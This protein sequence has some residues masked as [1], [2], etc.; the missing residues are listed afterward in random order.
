MFETVGSRWGG[1]SGPFLLWELQ[2][3]QIGVV[4]LQEGTYSLMDTKQHARE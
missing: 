2:V 4:E 3:A 1:V